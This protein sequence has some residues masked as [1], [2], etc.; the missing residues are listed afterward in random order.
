MYGITI[1]SAQITTLIKRINSFINSKTK[2]T[3][4]RDVTSSCL[5]CGG[6]NMKIKQTRNNA[7]QGIT[8]RYA[9]CNDC[10]TT[11]KQIVSTVSSVEH[12]KAITIYNSS[13]FKEFLDNRSINIR[14]G[15]VKLVLTETIM[16]NIKDT[17]FQKEIFKD[18]VLSESVTNSH[19]QIFDKGSYNEII[20]SL[21]P[22]KI[23]VVYES[24]S[25]NLSAIPIF[26]KMINKVFK[27]KNIILAPQDNLKMISVRTAHWSK[28]IKDGS[29]NIYFKCDKGIIIHEPK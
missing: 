21:R 7:K 24:F 20:G 11:N 23:R 5:P 25:E 10:R 4:V 15:K 8:V 27:N 28:N 9:Y 12:K 19:Q 6:T 14:N 18:S 26:V 3:Y 22:V 13:L 1:L 16:S 29:D 2:E 17:A